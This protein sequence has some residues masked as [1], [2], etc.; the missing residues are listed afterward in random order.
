MA[1][2]GVI[3]LGKSRDAPEKA[4][5]PCRH[6]EEGLGRKVGVCGARNQSFMS[7]G[8]EGWEDA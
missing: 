6:P 2:A 4:L 5:R 8:K 7:L 3:W 1:G